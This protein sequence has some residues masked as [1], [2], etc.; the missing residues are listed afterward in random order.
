[1]YEINDLKIKRSIDNSRLNSVNWH[2]IGIGRSMTNQSHKS[3]REIRRL[4]SI[5]FRT[6]FISLHYQ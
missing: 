6:E 1:M 2:L 3:S 4:P 5:G